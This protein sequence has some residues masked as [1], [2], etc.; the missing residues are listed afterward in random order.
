MRAT[1]AQ[2][3]ARSTRTP[4]T[5]Y[6]IATGDLKYAADAAGKGTHRLIR[7]G[8]RAY[9]HD[10]NGNTTSWVQPCAG[11]TSTISR[12]FKWDAENRVTRIA[13]GTNDTLYRYNSEGVAGTR[14]RARHFFAGLAS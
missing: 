13:E 14:G 6:V 1:L 3:A 9:T 2:A 12:T 5:T 10:N 4:K 11:G 8:T 7:S